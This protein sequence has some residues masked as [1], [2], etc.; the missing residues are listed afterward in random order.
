MFKEWV[1]DL[2]P[3]KTNWIKEYLTQAPVLIL[4]F[5]QTYHFNGDG[6]K[7]YHYYN[8]FSTSIATGILLCALQVIDIS[9]RLLLLAIFKLRIFTLYTGKWFMFID[10]DSNE[11]WV[12]ASGAI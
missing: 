2:K 1:D 12:T 8:E 4:V 10:Y 9:K 6:V 5:K 7:K 3:L 11:L